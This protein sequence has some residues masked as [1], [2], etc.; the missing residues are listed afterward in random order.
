LDRPKRRENELTRNRILGGSAALIAAVVAYSLVPLLLQPGSTAVLYFSDFGLLAIELATLT[1]CCLAAG[2]AETRGGRWVW[3][4]ISLWLA[5]NLFADSVWTYYDVWLHAAV[6]TPSLADVGY[7]LAY[8]LAFI[9]VVIGARGFAGRLRTLEASLDALMLTVGLAGVSWPFFLAPLLSTS[10]TGVEYWVN[11]A[12]PVGDLLVILAFVSLLLTTF[13][14]RVPRYFLMICMSF[15]VQVVADSAYFALL[16]HGGTYEGGGWLDSLWTLA[17]ALG[18]VAALVGMRSDGEKKTE[19]DDASGRRRVGVVRSWLSANGRLALPYL[20]L[21][22]VAGMIVLQLAKTGRTW[23]VEMQ[24]LAYLGLGLVVL[25]ICRQYLTLFQNRRLNKRLSGISQELT[26]RVDELADL[27]DRLEELNERSYRLSAL[28]SL[29][30]IAAEGIALACWAADSRAGWITLIDEEGREQVAAVNGHPQMTNIDGSPRAPEPGVGEDVRTVPL[31]ARGN[32]LGKLSVIREKEGNSG[33]DLLQ[34]ISAHLGTAIDNIRR[35]DE[36]V[37]LARRDPL[38]GLLNHRSVYSELLS[39]CSRADRHGSQ[40]SVVMMDLDDFKL[41]NDTYGHPVGDQVLL[42][43]SGT[44]QTILRQSDIAGRVGGDELMLVLPET[45]GE[46]ALQL[47]DRLRQMLAARPF[48]TPRGL[49]IPLRLSLG[50]ATYPTDGASLVNLVEVADANLYLSKQ[51]GGNA[52]TGCGYPSGVEEDGDGLLG[53]AGKLLDVVGARDHYTRRHSEQ[54]VAHALALG[55]AI[56]LPEDSLLTLRLAAMVHDV[57]KIGVPTRILRRPGPLDKTEE[58]AARL[59][60]DLGASIVRDMPRIEEVL[61]AVEAHHERIDG[62]GCPAGVPGND[63]PL[64]A[65]ILA[66]ADAYAAMTVDRPYRKG[67]G[68]EEAQAELLRV[69]GTQLDPSLVRQFIGTLPTAA[70]AALTAG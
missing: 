44:I 59:H 27:S 67:M 30:E 60:V 5:A 42:Q 8:P 7:L 35:Y 14:G 50:V 24:T 70:N 69:A 29:P 22:M 48:T 54:V 45:D 65:K 23:S 49:S 68:R 53:V 64:L 18:G 57:G 58:H 34:A 61:L 12:Y 31:E 28:R 21:P 16:A 41:L 6:P 2:R 47:A 11:L 1:L 19:A 17:I 20:A 4:V 32:S 46:G 40:L 9:T 38:T 43:V 3:I 39:E 26:Q 62:L 66:I 36:A 10:G 51:R 56:G 33:P 15:V 25:L 13:R 37:H 55:E 63:I 52:I